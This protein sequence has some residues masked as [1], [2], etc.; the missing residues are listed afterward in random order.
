[1]KSVQPRRQR[2]AR[3]DAPLH[4]RQKYVHAH[5]SPALREKHG[6]RNVQIRKGDKVKVVRGQFATKEGKVDKVNLQRTKVFISGI[7]VV[8]KEGARV[9]IPLSPSNLVVVELD[10]KDPRRKKKL[11]KKNETTS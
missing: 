9:P 6:R 4:T 3:Y 2:K 5:L 1:M 7:E 8:K 10:L 11:E